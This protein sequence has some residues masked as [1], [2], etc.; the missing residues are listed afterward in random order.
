[1]AVKLELLFQYTMSKKLNK[2]DMQEQ[3]NTVT[4]TAE[5]VRKE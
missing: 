2:K 3:S 5:Q 1:M 4:T